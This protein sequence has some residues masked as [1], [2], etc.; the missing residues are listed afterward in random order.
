MRG[1]ATWLRD[2]TALL[3]TAHRNFTRDYDSFQR[4][5]HGLQLLFML[6]AFQ[7]GFQ[8]YHG[9]HWDWD[10][11]RL[12]GPLAAAQSG[13]WFHN[14]GRVLALDTLLGQ[15]HPRRWAV[16]MTIYAAFWASQWIIMPPMYSRSGVPYLHALADVKIAAEAA[17]LLSRWNRNASGSNRPITKS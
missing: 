9:G 8:L 2:V 7:F 14:L 5:V 11:P 17:Y 13:G 1:G 10:E 15:E 4:I 6:G 12:N 16:L 3:R